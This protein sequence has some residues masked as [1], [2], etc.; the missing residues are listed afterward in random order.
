MSGRAL[1]TAVVEL[2]DAARLL[3]DD[4]SLIVTA[5]PDKGLEIELDGATL[6]LG[7]APDCEVVLHDPTISG[8]H[9]VV[10][11]GPRG[12]FVRDLGSKNGVV[13]EGW[14]IDAV[15]LADGMKLTLGG[16]Q[17]TVRARGGRR[18]IPL[19]PAGL[20]HELVAR[21]IPM[22]AVA[23]ALEAAA[24]RDVTVL[25][26]GETGTGKEI[27]AR[28]LHAA[29]ERASGPF[30]V[31]DCGA[32]TPSLAAAELFGHERGSFTGADRAQPGAL[33]LAEGG[34]L[35]LDELGELPLDLQPLLLG[36][37]ER[38]AGR[39]VGGQK[40]VAYDVRV[41]TAT[42]RNL[43]EEVRGGRFRA[44]LFY[45]IAVVRVRLPPLRDRRAD[46]PLLVAR[47][48][49][50]ARVTV[51]P[52]LVSLLEAHDWPGNVRELKHTLARAALDLSPLPDSPDAPI[53]LSSLPLP[54]ARR[55]AGEEF[56]RGYLEAL[57]EQS[58]GVLSRAA[59][60]AGVS[61]QALTKLVAKHG[62]RVRDRG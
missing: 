46:L 8:R 61:R 9:A 21:S 48:A 39:R 51:T 4:A 33:E 23:A 26:E 37:L 47:L 58:G 49:A 5:G 29:S 15:P 45:R 17:L 24:R 30:I 11:L 7:S 36:A 19:G 16:T 14:K 55:R 34:T 41:V 50:E 18:E 44:D 52:E 27:A 22:R 35:F 28:A 31:F 53:A 25:L 10:Q 38:R 54:E 56:E 43:A 13:L 20:Y 6:R 60:R 57:I 62:L 42:N 32:I 2:A 1:T 59:E 12:F 3:L 40:E